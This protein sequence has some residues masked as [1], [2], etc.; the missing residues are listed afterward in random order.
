MTSHSNNNSQLITKRNYNTVTGKFEPI[1]VDCSSAKSAGQTS[2]GARTLICDSTLKVQYVSK[3]EYKISNKSKKP[4]SYTWNKQPVLR[5]TEKKGK[6]VVKYNHSRLI[7]TEL[8]ILKRLQGHPNIVNVI[9]NVEVTYDRMGDNESYYVMEYCSE[10]NCYTYIST[11]KYKNIRNDKDLF[12]KFISNFIKD[13][14]SGIKYI[15][16]KK[17]I[18]CDIKPE[19]I[20][21][22]KPEKP[23]TKIKYVDTLVFKIGDLGEAIDYYNVIDKFTQYYSPPSKYARKCKYFIDYY[24]FAMSLCILISGNINAPDRQERNPN[25]KNYIRDVLC[26]FDLWLTNE[27]NKDILTLPVMDIVKNIYTELAKIETYV[28]DAIDNTPQDKL[29]ELNNKIGLDAAVYKEFFSKMTGLN[30]YK[31]TYTDNN[32]TQAE[33]NAVH[34]KQT[35]LNAYS[36]S[37]RVF[38]KTPG[39]KSWFRRLRGK[40]KTISRS[41][42]LV[43]LATAQIK[44]REHGT[45]VSVN[46]LTKN[47]SNNASRKKPT[48]M[49]RFKKTF[50][51]LYK[52]S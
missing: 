23:D 47:A 46:M 28:I 7:E 16:S 18:H 21:I 34:V 29:D 30:N 39:I 4:I 36:R 45:N 15:H 22:N 50:K 52:R 8:S 31:L 11:E 44:L 49:E 38:R 41:K 13:I 5:E 24:G 25:N 27:A 26:N 14:Y 51:N 37:K 1:T 3:P 32:I 9:P 48:R 10:G 2:P 19:N 43:R 20:F 42:R 12:S 17:I 33:I 6:F 40:P 35:D